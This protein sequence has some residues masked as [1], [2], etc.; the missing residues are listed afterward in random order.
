[1]VDASTTSRYRAVNTTPPPSSRA[2]LGPRLFLLSDDR[3]E[4]VEYK[5]C[6]LLHRVSSALL[7][8]GHVLPSSEAQ[9]EISMQ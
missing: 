2:L 6:T 4:G 5:L 9:L 8:F 3:F 1:M 7:S